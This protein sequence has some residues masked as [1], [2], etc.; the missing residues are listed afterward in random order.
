MSLFVILFQE[1]IDLNKFTNYIN[2][3]IA[4]KAINKNLSL[5]NSKQFSQFYSQFI[6][7]SQLI[8]INYGFDQLL[9]LNKNRESIENSETLVNILSNFMTKYFQNNFHTA[10]AEILTLKVYCFKIN[11][12]T[13]GP[14]KVIIS[15]KSPETLHFNQITLTLT[16]LKMVFKK[17]IIE[18]YYFMISEVLFNIPLWKIREIN[19]RGRKMVCKYNFIN[20][21]QS[22][23]I[24][25]YE[26]C[27]RKFL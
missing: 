12:E 2:S 8:I 24:G 18:T 15:T 19:V 7:C 16:D 3:F 23:K 22:G 25:L 27:V 14:G 11:Q 10:L 4:V 5:R 20:Y 17:L 1:Q 21:I 9:N 13:S 26:I 6:Y